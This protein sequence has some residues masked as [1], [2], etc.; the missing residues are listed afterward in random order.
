[1][2]RWK[3]SPSWVHEQQPDHDQRNHAHSPSLWSQVAADV[4]TSKPLVP[5]WAN[6][7]T[8]EDLQDLLNQNPAELREQLPPAPEIADAKDASKV[9]ELV[10]EPIKNQAEPMDLEPVQPELGV[11]EQFRP[12]QSQQPR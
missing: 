9:E 3:T 6:S 2:E 7:V 5:S 11:Q 10:A 8:K 4:A 1:M 12:P